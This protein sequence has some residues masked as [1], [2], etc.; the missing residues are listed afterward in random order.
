[1]N[2]AAVIECENLSKQ[3]DDSGQTVSVL[4]DVSLRIGPGQKFAVMGRSG[5]GKSTLL[6]LLGGLDRP[7]AGQVRISG[8][9]L[10]LLGPRQVGRLRNQQL[11][12]V[13]QFHHLMPEFT[14]L[15]NVAMP[16]LIR[17][18]A[19]RA[20]AVRAREMLE[21]VGLDHRLQ[22]KPSQLSGGERQRVAL[23]RAVVSQ[24]GCLLA[25]EPT[26]NL[27]QENA[28]KIIELLNELHKEFNIAIVLVT[29]DRELAAHMEF[30]LLL[31]DGCLQALPV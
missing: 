7:S 22:H 29:H 25:D 6:H 31:Q 12:F 17:G 21:R 20:A 24:P 10:S 16:L 4:S 11:G 13:Y 15:E 28:I 18:E 27:D 26:G 8:Q 5:A 30:Q 19:S 3:F 1:M 9:D 14:A 2:N 23:A